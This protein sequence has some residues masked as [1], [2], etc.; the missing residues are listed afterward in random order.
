MTGDVGGRHAD[1]SIP[2]ARAGTER[3]HEMRLKV[4]SKKQMAEYLKECLEQID[5]TYEVEDE[6]H[7]ESCRGRTAL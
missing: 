3:V 2:S 1:S 6:L 7:F 4:N 5:A